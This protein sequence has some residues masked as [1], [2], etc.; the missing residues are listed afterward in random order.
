MNIGVGSFIPAIPPH[1]PVKM[2]ESLIRE[3]RSIPAYILIGNEWVRV[4]LSLDREDAKTWIVNEKSVE[5]WQDLFRNY[6]APIDSTIEPGTL[7]VA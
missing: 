2:A 4:I 6:G 7:M 5:L 1:I 3:N